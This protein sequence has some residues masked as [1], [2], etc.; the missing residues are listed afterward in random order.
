[1]ARFDAAD[2]IPVH[3]RIAMAHSLEI[4]E[5][6]VSENPVML[7]ELMGYVRATVRFLDGRSASTVA[8]FRL[9]ATKG[10]QATNP[11][12]DAE[13]S[14]VGRALAMLGMHT[15]RSIAS[16]EE[17]ESAK[18]RADITAAINRI[19]ELE[20]KICDDGI[21]FEHECANTYHTT[22]AGMNIIRLNRRK[23]LHNMPF[24][25]LVDYGKFL[26]FEVL[27]PQVNI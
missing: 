11:L 25:S 21:L 19:N 13:T 6:I 23:P 24:E 26:K 27:G 18:E 9:D 1:M 5:S 15:S 17:V 3:E 2:Y 12:E 10:A 8:S 7:T 16:R 22:H 14:A 20:Q 4:L